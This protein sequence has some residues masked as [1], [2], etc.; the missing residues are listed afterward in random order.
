MKRRIAALC[1]ALLTAL[2]FIGCQ[3]AGRP[4]N[5]DVVATDAL[6]EDFPFTVHYI[7]VG[8][9]D[10]A[11]ILC[12]GEAMLIDGGNVEDSD[13]MYAY[14]QEYGVDHLKYV[15]CTHAH[16][17][18]VGG[19]AGALHYATADMALC[20]V[21]EYPSKAFESFVNR[22]YEQ[23]VGISVPNMG[24]ILALGGATAEILGPINMDAE[25]P[26]NT[27]IVLRIDYGDTSFLFTGD[28]EREE[29]QDILAAGYDVKCDVLKVGHHGS[30][31]STTYPW[32]YAADPQYAVISVGKDNSYGHPSEGTLS[33]LRDADVTLFRTDINGT[34][35]AGSDGET[36]TFAVE[37]NPDADTYEGLRES[38]VTVGQ[39]VLNTNTLKF[40]RP[41]CSSVK[42]INPANREDY[43]GPRQELLDM[44]YA[45][46]NNCKP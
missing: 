40:H 5:A 7:D 6:P 41:T 23:G 43:T 10:A 13:L 35:V 32:L 34:V 22:L 16:E 17:D 25:E 31:S 15:V 24:D 42:D 44:G 19:L 28:A 9:A 20:P 11:L 38:D 12:D 46:C 14:L 2:A 8:Q 27:S 45:P 1:L 39:Y 36:V 37:R 29:E 33:R 4:E 21:E 18:H 26:N 3:S 30:S